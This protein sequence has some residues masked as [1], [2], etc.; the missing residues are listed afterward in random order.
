MNGTVRI[1]A[2][3]DVLE[4]I[5][6]RL[7]FPFC[8]IDSLG[9][10]LSENSP[11]P[12]LFEV[13]VCCISLLICTS[14][15]VELLTL[16]NLNRWSFSENKSGRTRN[17]RLIPLVLSVEC[18]WTI[19]MKIDS[20]IHCGSQ[21]HSSLSDVRRQDVNYLNRKRSTLNQKRSLVITIVSNWMGM[22][23]SFEVLHCWFSLIRKDDS[24]RMEKASQAGVNLLPRRSLPIDAK[25]NAEKREE[26]DR[27]SSPMVSAK[28][29]PI[30][31]SSSADHSFHGS[32]F[33]PVH[34][35]NDHPKSILWR[36]PCQIGL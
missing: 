33:S 5:L 26:S 25:D 34:L 11:P 24:R 8:S 27:S 17:I 32:R 3:R 20:S 19:S 31:I 35:R 36:F 22:S 18:L 4:T 7:F 28:A 13:N 10:V 16:N 14:A 15:S 1:D 29:I 6:A 23:H 12:T 9:K 30:L 21:M 2:F